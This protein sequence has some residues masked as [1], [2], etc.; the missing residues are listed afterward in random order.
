MSV[1]PGAPWPSDFL[2]S[3]VLDENGWLSEHAFL[4]LWTLNV[5]LNLPQAFEQ[6]A[7][8]GF[9]VSSPSLSV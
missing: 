9:N 4:N 1:C 8:L 6:L 2:H 7:Y 5:A 3:T